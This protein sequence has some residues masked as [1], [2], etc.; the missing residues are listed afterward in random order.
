MTKSYYSISDLILY[1]DLLS[2]GNSGTIT[3][4]FQDLNGNKKG[5]WSKQVNNPDTLLFNF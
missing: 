4:E 5:G 1:L 2:V 3:V